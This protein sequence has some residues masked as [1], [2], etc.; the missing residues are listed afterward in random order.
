M[1][2]GFFCAAVDGM[3]LE[4]CDQIWQNFASLGVFTHFGHYLRLYIVCAANF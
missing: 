4:Q 3:E 1:L 2:N